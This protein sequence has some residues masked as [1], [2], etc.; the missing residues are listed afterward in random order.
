MRSVYVWALKDI[1]FEVQ[2][3]DVLGIIGKN[4]TGKS[5]LL[6]IIA[7]VEKQFQG[8]VHFK[9]EHTIGYLE[10]EPKLDDTKTVMDRERCPRE[11]DMN[12][13][14]EKYDK[15][16]KSATSDSIQLLEEMIYEYELQAS[17]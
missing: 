16:K 4:G 7:G 14:N 10:Q 11:I 6:K 13:R 3:G 5:T 17:K 8:D 1:N 15:I 9:G 2:T 12:A